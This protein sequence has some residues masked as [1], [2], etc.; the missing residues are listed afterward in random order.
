MRHSIYIWIM[1]ALVTACATEQKSED[2]SAHAT[3]PA[4]TPSPGSNGLMLTES[5]I[6]LA[7]ITTEKVSMQPVGQTQLINGVL[8]VDEESSQVISTRISG[9]LDRLF[10]KEAGR[11]IRQGEPLY[12]IY[13]EELLTLQKEFLLAKEQFETLGKEEPRYESYLKTAE[14]KLSLYGISKDQI[15]QLRKSGVQQPRITFFAPATGI[16]TEINAAEGQYVN[17]GAL[18]YRIESTIKLWVEADLYSDESKLVKV[19]DQIS[20]RISGYESTPVD[21][22]V[23]FLSPEYRANTQIVVMRGVIENREMMFK[24][25]MQAQVLFTH[26]SRKALSVPVDAVIRDEHGTHVYIESG[27][28]TFEPRMV[29]TGVEDF[30]QVEVIEGLKEN[31]SVVATGAYLLYSEF[32]LRRGADPMAGHNH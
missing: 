4:T 26:S 25:G 12:E 30:E 14:K 11:T 6:R 27:K 17:E 20:V 29:K 5:Q 16:I 32:I 1:A 18:L 23:V 7:N 22:K 24:P 31:E 10:F 3:P 8:A 15:E 19:G 2:H 28:F 9:R 13:S 21:A